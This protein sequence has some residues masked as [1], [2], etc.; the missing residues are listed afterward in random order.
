MT[1]LCKADVVRIAHSIQTRQQNFPDEEFVMS[2][3]VV[4]MNYGDRF[5]S[6]RCVNGEWAG[7]KMNLS[8]EGLP[9]CPNGHVL[10]ESEGRKKLVLVEENQ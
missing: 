5:T 1:E 7:Q 8:G 3:G 10:L 2:V 9:K 6:V 4:L